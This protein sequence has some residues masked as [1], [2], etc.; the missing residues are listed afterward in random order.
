MIT[1]LLRRLDQEGT[2]ADRQRALFTSGLSPPS[3]VQALARASLS[4]SM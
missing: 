3:F 1:R 4:R 2:G